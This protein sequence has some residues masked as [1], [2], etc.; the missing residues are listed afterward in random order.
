V[1]VENC[2][3]NILFN[4]TITCREDEEE[5]RGEMEVKHIIAEKPENKRKMRKREKG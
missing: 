4:S 5:K 1:D 3:T 2:I